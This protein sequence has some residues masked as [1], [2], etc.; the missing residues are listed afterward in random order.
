MYADKT[1]NNNIRYY[2][3]VTALDKGHNESGGGSLGV[4]SVK[5]DSTPSS[6]YSLGQNYPNPFSDRTY[7]SY[8]LGERSPVELIVMDTV[9]N[10]KFLIVRE[11]Q[12]AGTYIVAVEA[13][14]LARG[15]YVYKL[16]AGS[17]VATRMLERVD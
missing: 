5:L 6:R 15:K 12:D 9:T 8:Q 10:K 11:T 13:K 3:A 2:Y 14:L 4:E 17:F 1:T 16:K 7:I